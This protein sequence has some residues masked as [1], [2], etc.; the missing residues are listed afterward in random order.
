MTMVDTK[1]MACVQL[2]ASD[3]AVVPS[4]V[5]NNG[6]QL[7]S[8]YQTLCLC[9]FR[10][11]GWAKLKQSSTKMAGS[12]SA[13]WV[14]MARCW[15]AGQQRVKLWGNFQKGSAYQTCTAFATLQER[16]RDLFRANQQPQQA[17]PSPLIGFIKSLSFTWMHA[18]AQNQN[19]RQ[20]ISNSNSWTLSKNCA[21]LQTTGL[22]SA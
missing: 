13:V 6:P 3:A 15:L 20:L 12:A 10:M 7:H 14:G 16:S 11:C 19:Q 17:I 22:P 21:L 18:I 1:G 4:L 8:H 5:A 9:L 2:I